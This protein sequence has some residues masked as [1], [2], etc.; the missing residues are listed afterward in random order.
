MLDLGI[1]R[2]VPYATALLAELGAD[3]TKVEPP[4]GDPM[5]QF[6]ALFDGLTADKTCVELDLK[7]DAGRE[8]A[9]DLAAGSDVVA[10]GFRKGVV[11]RLG[12]GYDD[13]AARNPRVVYCSL[14][15]DAVAG[16]D[17]NYQA[18]SGVLAL[19][20][21]GPATPIVP[22][23]DLVAALHAAFRIAA[24][25]A[26]PPEQRG[27]HLV[28]DMTSVLA[29]WA[30]SCVPA[31]LPGV[32]GYGVFATRDGHV[33]LGVLAEDHLW[34]S[35]CGALGID[36]EVAGLTFHQRVERLDDLQHRIAA[37]LADTRRD[38]AVTRLQLAGAPAT[39][40]RTPDELH[41]REN[42]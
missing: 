27:A 28:L 26:V 30:R 23:A 2:P 22:W 14:R 32:P 38:D 42:P 7:T 37:A 24:A 25:L 19:Q 17:V 10:E 31:P 12:V 40:V 9:L 8:K 41:P 11:E 35:T 18:S 21:G 1:W 16:H 6:P 36:D 4:G 3:V 20:P 29:D 13:V 34:K 5:R 39:A 33:A 15:D